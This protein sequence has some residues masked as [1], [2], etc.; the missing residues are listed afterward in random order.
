MPTKAKLRFLLITISFEILFKA[1]I[2]QPIEGKWR[3][4]IHYDNIEVPFAFEVLKSTD[5]LTELLIISSG[6]TMEINNARLKGDSLFVP[7]GVFDS[8]L[9]IRYTNTEMS[10][11]WHK[12]YQQLPGPLF[13]ATYKQDIFSNHSVSMAPVE[14][15]DRWRIT[16]MQPSGGISKALGLF[17]QHE[18]Q[19][20]GT[21]LTEV[22]DYR[23]FE[24]MIMNDSIVMSSFDGVH[25]FLFA[26]SYHVTGWK[27]RLYYEPGYYENWEAMYDN[28]YELTDP[29]ELITTE[30]GASRPYYDI[31][32]AGGNYNIIN[33]DSLAGK[34]VVI[35]LMGTW[36]PN[37]FDQT[38]YLVNWCK[39]KPE[40][41]KMIAVSYEPGDKSYAHQ[42]LEK[43]KKQMKIPYPMYVGGS[44]SKGQAALA[45]PTI[46]R[47]NA[48]PTLVMIDKK[49]FIRYI[50]SYF[51]GP[52][53]GD[54]YLKFGTEFE[55]RIEELRNE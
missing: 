7:L 8:E 15:E 28:T 46:D 34:V 48:F 47:I 9:R 22:G 45:F 20:A 23:Y 12:N 54:Y 33:T 26:G 17:E 18:N 49:G 30:P 21:I 13:T 4:A 3:G 43:Y 55:K 25:A 10:G 16:L 42:R 36:C 39:S 52:A 38:N 1:A 19:I 11:E 40:D 31:L 27:G 29:F 32:T 24:G 2:S 6:D 50:C 41:V 53:T 37:S 51:N 35:Q 14:I 44:L 5:S